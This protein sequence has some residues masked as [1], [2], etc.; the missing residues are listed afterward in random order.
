MDDAGLDPVGVGAAQ[1]ALVDDPQAGERR[2]RRQRLVE[3]QQAIW[4]HPEAR[5]AFSTSWSA[6]SSG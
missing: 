3:R 4:L 1:G 6:Y 2:Q 5:I